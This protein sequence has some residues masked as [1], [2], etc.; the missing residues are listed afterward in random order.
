MQETSF[1]YTFS[2]PSVKEKKRFVILTPEVV[3][4]GG[5]RRAVGNRRTVGNRRDGDKM[6][7]VPVTT[8][9]RCQSYDAITSNGMEYKLVPF[10]CLSLFPGLDKHTSLLSYRNNSFYDIVP[11]TS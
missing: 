9:S 2:S 5:D 1:Y 7:I 10:Y 4:G 6:E 11:P 8:I 3:G